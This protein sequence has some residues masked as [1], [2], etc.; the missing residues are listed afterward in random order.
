MA[1]FKHLSLIS[2]A[3]VYDEYYQT[4][5]LFGA[6]YPELI[7]FLS[8]YPTR[9]KL[10]D[11]GCG[12]GRD[13][14]PI[15]RLGFDVTGIDNSKVGIEQMKQLSYRENL[16]VLGIVGDI[17]AYNVFKDF[18]FILLDSMFHFLK[19]DRKKETSFIKKIIRDSKIGAIIIFCIQNTGNKVKILN[20][21]IDFYTKIRR[22]LEKDLVYE[23]KDKQTGHSSKTNYKMIVIS[24]H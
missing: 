5:N 6:P 22:L 3:V 8:N 20:G 4:E 24:K 17:Y 11:V 2:M 10:L 9:G 7:S 16:N 23:Y 1:F 14:I 15:A 18:D 21:T 12:Q 13:A 19:K